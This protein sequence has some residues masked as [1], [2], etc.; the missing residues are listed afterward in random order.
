MFHAGRILPLVLVVLPSLAFA[1][2]HVWVNT[3]VEVVL[4][5][6]Y[7]EKLQVEWSFDELF[8]QMVLMDNDA[9][10][11]GQLN[12]AES[13]QVKK[14]YFDNLKGYNYFAHLRLG[15]TELTIPAVT[16]F[17][18]TINA[19][20]RAV[21]R[22]SLA[23]GQRLDAKTAF[24]FG[25]YDETFYTDM[26]F[27]KRDPVVLTVTEGGKASVVVKPNPAKAFYGG[28]VVPVE[29]KVSWRPS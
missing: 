22:F 4:V 18:A 29:A 11:D 1:H 24:A 20:G 16:E 14:T 5:A 25:F 12:A 21:Y 10:G 6:G 17:K 19:A 7:L 3:K 28:Q 27:D 23:V 8:T 2:P 26:V 13:A 9:N 15:K